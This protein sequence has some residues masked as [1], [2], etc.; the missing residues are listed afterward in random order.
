MGKFGSARK[1]L[2]DGIAYNIAAD[3][4]ISR[5]P[6]LLSEAIPHSGGNDMKETTQHGGH[7][8]NTLILS[9]Q[10]HETLTTLHESGRDDIPMS[11]TMASGSVYTGKGWFNMEPYES[12]EGRCDITLYSKTGKF[13]LFAN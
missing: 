13:D 1:C 4:N 8:S 2:I 12:E 9:E 7:E 10:E 3:A 5:T 11:Y 6:R